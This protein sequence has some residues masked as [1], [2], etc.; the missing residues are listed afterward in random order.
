[1]PLNYDDDNTTPTRANH[2]PLGS[3]KGQVVFA[4]PIESSF[5]TQQEFPNQGGG[6][7]PPSATVLS[8]KERMSLISARAVKLSR[9]FD[10]C[11]ATNL[12]RYVY[13]VLPPSLL[14]LQECLQR[15][16][17]AS[18]IYQAPY[19]S[20]DSDISEIPKEFAGLIYR[21]KG[22]Q[23]IA[24]LEEWSTNGGVNSLDVSHHLHADGI[25]GWEYAGLPPS[26]K[27]V[28]LGLNCETIQ[29]RRNEIFR[30]QVP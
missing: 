4:E 20:N 1:M 6:G 9:A 3:I 11:K 18:K 16:S 14:D 12:N 5:N 8:A 13:S 28:R 7:H 15:F 27:E 24:T 10:T 30:S 2:R 26:V 21:L 25:G 22:G 17:L 19:Y 29:R 23:G